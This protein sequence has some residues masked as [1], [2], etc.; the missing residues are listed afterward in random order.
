MPATLRSPP[1]A[2]VAPGRVGRIARRASG[3][4]LSSRQPACSTV[5]ACVVDRSQRAAT[6]PQ[7]KLVEHA[8]QIVWEPAV[9]QDESNGDGLG[10]LALPQSLNTTLHQFLQPVPNVQLLDQK[11][12]QSRRPSKGFGVGDDCAKDVGPD[13]AP[14]APCGCSFT[15][16][17]H[18][19]AA[20]ACRDRNARTRTR[21]GGFST[22]WHVVLGEIGVRLICL[23]HSQYQGS[24][25]Q[26]APY[27][28]GTCLHPVGRG[29]T[30][31]IGYP[32]CN[33]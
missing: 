15:P 7:A 4:R 25:L 6:A 13:F 32:E 10:V 5:P 1:R 12:Q 27:F 16:G 8:I 19:G 18:A 20:P 30:S 22:R 23:F 28:A 3:A 17:L 14:P 29:T 9:S 33:R 24:S 26:L 31:G 11:L 2:R 21:G